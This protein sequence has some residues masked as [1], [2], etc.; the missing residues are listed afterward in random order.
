MRLFTD[1][2]E[3]QSNKEEFKEIKGLLQKVVDGLVKENGKWRSHHTC[4]V[5]LFSKLRKGLILYLDENFR[6]N[7]FEIISN[8]GLKN[9]RKLKKR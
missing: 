2:N 8:F 9:S 1:M 5:E 3:V 6:F 4:E 7:F